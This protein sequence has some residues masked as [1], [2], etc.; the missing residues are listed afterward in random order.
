MDR[1]SGNRDVKTQALA[2]FAAESMVFERAHPEC[3]P[4]IPTR[5]TLH[6]GRQAFPFRDYKPVP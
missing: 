6:S 1:T 5:R 2:K 4:T 3:L